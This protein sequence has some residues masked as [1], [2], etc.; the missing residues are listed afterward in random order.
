M[1]DVSS[2]GGGDGG[3]LGGL[4]AALWLRGAGC[5]VA[6][7]ER[8]PVPLSGLGAGIVLNPATVRYFTEHGVVPEHR[9]RPGLR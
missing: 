3:S 5:D 9:R 8:S 4:S 1:N 6:V 2:E 7:F